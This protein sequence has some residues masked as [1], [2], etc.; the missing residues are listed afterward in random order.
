MCDQER[1]GIGAFGV[2]LFLRVYA[3]VYKGLYDTI[4]VCDQVLMVKED[5][6]L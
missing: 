2:D 3:A 5:V 6:V 1:Y 4:N